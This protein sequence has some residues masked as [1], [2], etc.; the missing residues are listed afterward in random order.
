MP[1]GVGHYSRYESEYIYLE[2][3]EGQVFLRILNKSE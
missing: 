3:D 2:E 1:Y